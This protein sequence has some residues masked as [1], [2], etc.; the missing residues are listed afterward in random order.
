MS[1]RRVVTEP[2]LQFVSSVT[3]SLEVTQLIDEKRSHLKVYFIRVSQHD[4]VIRANWCKTHMAE[5]GRGRASDFPQ[6]SVTSLAE[7]LHGAPQQESGHSPT[8]RLCPWT[9]G[10]NGWHWRGPSKVPLSSVLIS[11]IVQSWRNEAY[12]QLWDNN[13]CIVGHH[14]VRTSQWLSQALALNPVNSYLP[15]ALMPAK[16]LLHFQTIQTRSNVSIP[17]PKQPSPHDWSWSR[18]YRIHEVSP[19]HY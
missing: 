5:S 7:R 9:H 17:N 6:M 19:N 12:V 3:L 4:A 8:M 2:K 1:Q 11:L 13:M 15:P 10:P 14:D 18:V 16:C